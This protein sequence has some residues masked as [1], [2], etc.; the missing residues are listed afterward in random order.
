MAL[1]DSA[2]TSRKVAGELL[3]H[4]EHHEGCL[5]YY[6]DRPTTHIRIRKYE[7]DMKELLNEF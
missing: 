4:A 2:F 1:N 3:R 7:T 5:K 6:P